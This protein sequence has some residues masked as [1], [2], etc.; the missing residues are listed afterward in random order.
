MNILNIRVQK[1]Y[2]FV[3]TQFHLLFIFFTFLIYSIIYIR[4]IGLYEHRY[5]C[6]FQYSY[7]FVK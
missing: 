2:F 3:V 4:D 6:Y 7:R 5:I 1:I